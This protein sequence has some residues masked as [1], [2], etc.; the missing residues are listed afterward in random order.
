M[1]AA[2]CERLGWYDLEALIAKFQVD[3]LESLFSVGCSNW[4]FLACM[5]SPRQDRPV[6]CRVRRLGVRCTAKHDHLKHGHLPN[7]HTSTPQSRVLHGVRPEILA[8]SEIPFV[9][10]YTARL[11]YRAGLRCAT[12]VVL[13]VL[14]SVL[15]ADCTMWS[16]PV[17]ASHLAG[18]KTEP[19]SRLA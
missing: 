13:T 12:R 14:G 3:W 6:C 19:G 8:L 11:L 4:L 17:L 16:V 10:A 7:I 2:F 1:T 15:G 18:L 5:C 9:K